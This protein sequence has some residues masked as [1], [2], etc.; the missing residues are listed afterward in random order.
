MDHF[1]SFPFLIAV[2]RFFQIMLSK[3][4]KGEHSFIILTLRGNAFSFFTYEFDDS[5]EFVIYSL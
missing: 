5:C 1:V 4:A 3:S 2:A